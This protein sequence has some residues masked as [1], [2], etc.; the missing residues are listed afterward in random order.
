MEPQKVYVLQRNF[1]VH[2]V[3]TEPELAL[4]WI[5]DK[6]PKDGYVVVTRTL[7]EIEKP[8]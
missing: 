3:V 4:A 1:F 5:A 7:D 8:Y 2:G 6:N